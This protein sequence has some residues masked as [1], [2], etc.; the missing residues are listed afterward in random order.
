M[1]DLLKKLGVESYLELNSEEKETY[2]LWEETLNGRKIT[3]EEIKDFFEQELH[4]A[5]TRLT[6]TD[7]TKEQEIF[8]KMEVRFIKRL[9]M[10]INAPIMEKKILEENFLNK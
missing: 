7:L 10:F 3:D 6:E 8:R 4:S 2:K 5:I 9:Q 1:E